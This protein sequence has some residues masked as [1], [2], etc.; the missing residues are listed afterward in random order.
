MCIRDRVAAAG[1][2]V[3]TINSQEA[4]GVTVTTVYNAQ[5]IVQ[6]N[7]AVTSQGQAVT[8]LSNGTWVVIN[9]NTL[10]QEVETYKAAQVSHA[11]ANAQPTT[12]KPTTTGQP[13]TGKPTTTQ[14]TS[15]GSGGGNGNGDG[16]S[17]DSNG[18]NGGRPS[19]FNVSSG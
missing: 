10:A 17:G 6:T 1:L 8:Q 7:T 15:D 11:Q 4:D 19:W 16:S 9:D 18:G 13:T 5:N 12:T 2:S 3:T 14:P